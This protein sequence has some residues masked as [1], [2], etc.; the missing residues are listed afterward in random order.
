[1]CV[2]LVTKTI[3]SL[4]PSSSRRHHLCFYIVDFC[5]PR[6]EGSVS[7][8]D[9]ALLT[10]TDELWCS[11]CSNF[12]GSFTVFVF[13]AESSL[14]LEKR[15]KIGAHSFCLLES[16]MKQKFGQYILDYNPRIF[17]SNVSNIYGL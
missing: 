11:D 14:S 7:L 17:S 5:L 4:P 10:F 1:M 16:M 13:E 6:L 3:K 2:D 15:I 9:F 8:I 12:L